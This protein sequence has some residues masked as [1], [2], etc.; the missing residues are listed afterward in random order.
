MTVFTLVRHGQTDWNVARRYQ[1]QQDIPLNA[2][3]LRQ[4]RNL[5]VLLRD[6]RFD[7]I[8]SSDLQRAMQTAL[9]LQEGRRGEVIA[10]ARLREISFGEWEGTCLDDMH[11]TF[12]TRFA[13]SQND[14]AV[15]LAPG[16]ESVFAV[17][18]RTKEFA[19]EVSQQFPN[20]N[21]L[22][23]THGLALATLVCFAENKPIL[24]AYHLVP[25]NAQPVRITWL[26]ESKAI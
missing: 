3:G 19:Q 14:P 23:V 13:L 2:E 7:A 22:V 8:Y 20:G 12:P 21:V 16:G 24:E 6:E 18:Q 26:S 15:P 4:A 10:D 1:G 25:D 5:A 11:A 9:I 17:A